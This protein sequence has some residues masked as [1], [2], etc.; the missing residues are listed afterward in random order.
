MIYKSF[1][2][3]MRILHG[4]SNPG[5]Q[6]TK[7]SRAQRKLGY[8]SDCLI[9]EGNSFKVRADFNLELDK[10]TYLNAHIK[11][12]KAFLKFLPKYDVFHFHVGTFLNPCLDI[13]LLKMLDK[14]VVFHCHGYELIKALDP[15]RARIIY[16][17]EPMIAELMPK[18]NYR[19]FTRFSDAILVSEPDLLPYV[20]KAIWIPQPI[21]TEYWTSTVSRPS[22]S[23][24]KI[25]HTPSNKNKKGT[26]FVVSAVK[27]LK[28]LGYDLELEIVH[29]VPHREIKQYVERADIFV[30]QLLVGWYGNAAVEAMALE[31]PVC[32][33]IREDLEKY[34]G[35]CPVVNANPKNLFDKLKML[36]ENPSLRKDLGTQG[37]EYIE[38]YHSC[39]K[40]AEELIELYSKI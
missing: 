17:S 3:K 14:K 19:I 5:F 15:Q 20:P 39:L 27:K 23:S 13:P 37:R 16:G 25:V 26:R 6:C 18:M 21:D 8:K 38:E 29:G 34:L 28:S 30:D 2:Q 7:I 40:I 33:Y 22:T 12:L 31:K 11:R 32:V 35:E 24:L 9:D 10:A 4:T 1:Q 36:V